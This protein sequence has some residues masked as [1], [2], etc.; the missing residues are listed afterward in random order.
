MRVDREGGLFSLALFV[1]LMLFEANSCRAAEMLMEK[2][3]TTF[4]C[5][6]RLNDCL[7]AEDMELELLMDSHI[8]RM[9]IGANGKATIDFTNVAHKTVPC[10]PGKQYGPCINPKQ[11]KFRTI[12]MASIGTEQENMESLFCVPRHW[13]GFNAGINIHC[14][15]SHLHVICE[16]L[17]Q[18][19]EIESF[20]RTCFGHMMDVEADK[21]L[22]YAS[23]MHNLMLHRINEPDATEVELWFAIGKTKARISK[24]EF[25]LVTGLKF[26]PYRLSLSIPMRPSLE[27]F[28]YDI[29][30][31]GKR[32]VRVILNGNVCFGAVV[33]SKDVGA[34]RRRDVDRILD[35]HGVSPAAHHVATPAV[36]PPTSLLPFFLL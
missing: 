28:T 15:W 27:E 4:R 9:L 24:R 7:I 32:V 23:L 21:S 30:D 35:V 11:K 36:P 26:V 1:M 6:G 22:F 17:C 19:N 14:K 2:S 34:N 31:L 13:W 12:A 25:Y 16:M 8:S 10:G 33:G 20:K 5:S 18:V 29:G 3:N